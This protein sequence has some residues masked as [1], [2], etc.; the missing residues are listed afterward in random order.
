MK[1]EE[2]GI[3]ITILLDYKHQVEKRKVFVKKA[4][5]KALYKV[6]TR[7]LGLEL[8]KRKSNRCGCL[9]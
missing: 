7:F 8:G 2:E 1:I 3:G 6:V 4:V 5:A 9:F